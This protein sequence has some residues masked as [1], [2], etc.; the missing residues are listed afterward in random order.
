[1]TKRVLSVVIQYYS[2]LIEGLSN[3]KSGNKGTSSWRPE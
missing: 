3:V 2:L 1:M